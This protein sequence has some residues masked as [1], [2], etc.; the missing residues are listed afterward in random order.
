MRTASLRVQVGGVGYRHV[1]RGSQSLIPLL[2]AIHDS[3]SEPACAVSLQIL[4]YFRNAPEK[5]FLVLI[6]MTVVIQVVNIHF[7][8]TIAD[9]FEQTGWHSVANFRNDLAG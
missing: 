5:F 6:E 4:I 7:E 8:A 2:V 9:A 1:V 3:S